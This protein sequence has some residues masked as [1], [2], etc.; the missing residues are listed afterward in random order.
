MYQDDEFGRKILSS[1]VSNG[2]DDFF[3]G[4]LL[5]YTHSFFLAFFFLFY[6][7]L[8]GPFFLTR[9]SNDYNKISNSK[10]T[11]KIRKKNSSSLATSQ[12]SEKSQK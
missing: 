9:F 6:F 2:R 12:Y 8:F 7:F 3:N 1:A 4:L 11:R 10:I 5:P